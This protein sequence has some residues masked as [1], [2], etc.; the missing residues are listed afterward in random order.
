MNIQVRL[1]ALEQIDLLDTEGVFFGVLPDVGTKEDD[2]EE[3]EVEMRDDV[4]A[5]RQQLAEATAYNS[6]LIKRV[7][8]L[9]AEAEA[10]KA[11][12]QE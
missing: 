12:I 5:L 1:D 4:E 2:R 3:S 6:G 7:D 10:D 11:R 9:Q 8:T